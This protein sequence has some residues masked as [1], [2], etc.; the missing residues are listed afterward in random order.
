M[1][2]SSCNFCGNPDKCLAEKDIEKLIEEGA[3]VPSINTLI[4]T[5]K[6]VGCWQ[7]K[8]RSQSL[9]QNQ[10]SASSCPND[11]RSYP[12]ASLCYI[13]LLLNGLNTDGEKP[14]LPLVLT[15]QQSLGGCSYPNQI[16]TTYANASLL[17]YISSSIAKDANNDDTLTAK[18]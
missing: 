9:P 13:K 4:I 18:V 10:C 17:G 15:I 7:A 11:G 14:S 5:Y 1:V 3:S 6:L 12:L 16:I 8:I 2:E